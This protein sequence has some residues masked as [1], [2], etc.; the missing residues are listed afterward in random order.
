MNVTVWN[1]YGD[2]QKRRE[3][4]DVYPRGLHETIADF[5]N[6]DPDIQA[7][8]AVLANPEQGLS[9]AVL[10]HTDV[11]VW[12]GHVYHH[13]V[14]DETVQRVVDRVQRG[15]GMIFLHSAHKS[16]PFLR[17]LGASGRLSWREAN[18]KTRIWTAASG[19]P[20]TRGIPEQFVI[21]HEEMYSEP[22]GIPEPLQTVFISWFQGGNVFRSG[23]T[24]K[25]E[26][27]K[28]FYF[29]PGHETNPTYH[30]EIVQK[31]IVNAVK[32]A[33]PVIKVGPLDCPNA[34]QPLEKL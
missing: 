13:E 26:Y 31:V 7:K 24:F 12:W 28:V 18:E 19:H 23:V 30:H 3:V 25:K 2:A 16:K 29:Q 9:E 22:F 1:E 11:L 34:A 32:W 5:L 8:T 20:I 15:M 27:G 21:D 17:L 6:R 4:A 33:E 14:S 10:D